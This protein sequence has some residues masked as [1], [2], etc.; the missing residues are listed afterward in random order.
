M[1]AKR[2]AS[3]GEMSQNDSKDR[4]HTS[5]STAGEK[6]R[7]PPDAHA[8]SELQETFC[9]EYNAYPM[10]GRPFGLALVWG[11]SYQDDRGDVT[12][13]VAADR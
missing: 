8:A 9:N 4:P 5:T 13:M 12:L 2:R 1:S 6:F 10:R 3:P 7:L 11:Q